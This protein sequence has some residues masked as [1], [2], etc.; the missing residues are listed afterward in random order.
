LSAHIRKQ[1]FFSKSDYSREIGKKKGPDGKK[2]PQTGNIGG[3]KGGRCRQK[4]N[5]KEKKTTYA[6]K[7]ESEG[8]GRVQSAKGKN[9]LQEAKTACCREGYLLSDGGLK[10]KL[11]PSAKKKTGGSW[12]RKERDCRSLPEKENHGVR[13]EGNSRRT[14][15]CKKL[16][17]TRRSDI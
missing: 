11:T 13:R 14:R 6:L 7:R 5:D 10:D 15:T 9:C 2:V 8:W 17:G 4:R 12:R 1:S 16:G 3:R